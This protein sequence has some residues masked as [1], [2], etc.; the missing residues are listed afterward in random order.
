MADVVPE[1]WVAADSHGVSFV[2][3]AV[4][5]IVLGDE[6]ADEVG[7]VISQPETI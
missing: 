2:L 6:V 1:T 5:A 4:V 3:K 7:H